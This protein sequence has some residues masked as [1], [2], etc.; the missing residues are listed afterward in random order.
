MKNTLIVLAFIFA[1][2]ATKP[3]APEPTGSSMQVETERPTEPGQFEPYA[4]RTKLPGVMDVPG[5][6]V[7]KH[8]CYTVYY[9]TNYK[10][11]R[12]VTYRLKREDLATRTGKRKEN[13][14][15]DPM[16]RERNLPYYSL[17]AYRK[18]K[19][20]S[21]YAPGHLAPAADFA[22]S[23]KAM[24]ESFYLSNMV[25]QED[26]MNSPTWVELE[27]QVRFWA[28]GEKDVTVIT[29]G[30]LKPGLKTLST[31][32]PIPPQM[33]KVVIDETAPRKMI[34]FVYNQSD[35]GEVMRERVVS[36]AK[37]EAAAGYSLKN[38]VEGFEKL[39]DSGISEW[40][41]EDCLPKAKRKSK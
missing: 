5:V 22:R 16:L 41:S 14:K 37:I 34:G 17:A 12:H 20:D 19:V 39:K 32:V 7:L 25:P 36:V 27:D 2:C 24:D 4:K 15:I 38:D 40:K 28:C 9:D 13:F 29:G 33:F 1:G 10:L 8:T 23:Q 18:S 3:P 21:P 30:Y 26:A 31:G 35:R 11:A 6:E